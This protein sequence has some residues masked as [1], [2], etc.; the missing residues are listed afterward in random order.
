MIKRPNPSDPGECLPRLRQENGALKD[1]DWKKVSEVK[2]NPALQ[3]LKVKEQW[4]AWRASQ[5][6]KI[7]ECPSEV[8]IL[9]WIHGEAIHRMDWL[10]CFKEEC[11]DQEGWLE[12]MQ[13]WARWDDATRQRASQAWI[14][15]LWGLEECRTLLKIGPSIKR[16]FKQ[17]LLKGSDVK[18]LSLKKEEDLVLG[19]R[20][21][22]DGEEKEKEKNVVEHRNRWLS[23]VTD[24]DHASQRVVNQLER[25]KSTWLNPVE[26]SAFR[27]G[28]TALSAKDLRVGAKVGWGETGRMW[29]E[30]WEHLPAPSDEFRA[31][32]QSRVI[33]FRSF[34]SKV[35]MEAGSSNRMGGVISSL[36]WEEKM[37]GFFKADAKAQWGIYLNEMWKRGDALYQAKFDMGEAVLWLTPFLKFRE[38][39]EAFWEALLGMKEISSHSKRAFLFWKEW[40]KMMASE[41]SA[42]RWPLHD[43]DVLEMVVNLD[44]MTR[45][46]QC[47]P[48]AQK[49]GMTGLD[50][51]F[52][53]H[54][55]V[56][57]V[58]DV[59]ETLQQELS[60]EYWLLGMVSAR[61][62][63]NT[64]SRVDMKSIRWGVYQYLKKE[65]NLS[66]E[67]KKQAWENLKKVIE[68]WQ[69]EVGA[70]LYSVTQGT[71]TEQ[72]SQESVPEN[73]WW[74]YLV[75]R[76]PKQ[77]D[78]TL[79]LVQLLES[80]LKTHPQAFQKIDINE[81]E[82]L[83][84]AQKQSL[85]EK[86][87][88][89]ELCAHSDK[90]SPIPGER[91]AKPRL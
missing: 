17:G 27:S 84:V 78:Q 38:G 60:P 16:S 34:Y 53:I 71:P 18:N 56:G 26:V 48:Q 74:Q 10:A 12:W 36:A 62:A 91:G 51:A 72:L 66:H 73:W 13:E 90:R 3:K 61:P 28:I 43:K 35:E 14:R 4:G 5:F 64:P 45:I 8:V 42:F 89:C 80:V 54:H 11:S 47:L 41:A 32:M 33:L 7:K 82:A 55:W 24:T 63:Q 15:A 87:I 19:A 6:Q 1:L 9:D 49:N 31:L 79:P 69:E 68:R 76:I 85:K 37:P 50:L 44:W 57:H 86:F 30:A 67:S 88:K 46:E 29:Q 70:T 52:E 81:L 58:Y 65:S 40:L 23:W 22:G 77:L 83:S 25:E 59:E 20:E 21:G 2:N 39:Q 75:R